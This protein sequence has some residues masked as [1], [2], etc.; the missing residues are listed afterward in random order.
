M[1]MCC[2][3]FGFQISF[4]K[5]NPKMKVYNYD[6]KDQTK[7][8]KVRMDNAKASFKNTRETSR[9]LR[10]KTIPEAIK[11]LDDVLAH[12][13]CVPMRRYARGVGRT[14]QANKYGVQRGR[15]PEKSVK[16]FKI[17]IS[18]LIGYAGVK[19]IEK[20]DLVIKHV[21]VN[22]APVIYG[23]IYR[24]HGRVNAFNKKPCHVEMVA[25]KKEA[26][27]PELDEEILEN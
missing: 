6:I 16:L 13:T 3:F 1:K 17:L 20:E 26:E 11:Y 27:V 24:A 4:L 2:K 19:G 22:K 9:M 23:R 21:Q 12:K 14:A 7:A 8:V 5:N 15:W 18:K 10:G 25:E